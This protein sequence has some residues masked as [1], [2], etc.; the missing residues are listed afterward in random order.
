MIAN[1][2]QALEIKSQ[3]SN[4]NVNTSED[5]LAAPPK[6]GAVDNAR[7][8]GSGHL[9]PLCCPQIQV[10]DVFHH[11]G[12]T[13]VHTGQTLGQVMIHVLEN[14]NLQCL[15]AEDCLTVLSC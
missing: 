6:G 14:S 12:L 3:K 4:N 8:A 15:A 2:Q 7:F 10:I 5:L 9:W 11:V 1:P 13:V